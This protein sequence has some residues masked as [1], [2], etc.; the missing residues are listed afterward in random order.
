MTL[1][2]D[3]LQIVFGALLT[4][5]FIQIGILSPDNQFFSNIVASIFVYTATRILAL[6]FGGRR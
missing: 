1:R 5:L 6:I 3:L 4:A 2:R